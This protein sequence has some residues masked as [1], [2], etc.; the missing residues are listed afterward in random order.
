[1]N[2]IDVRLLRRRREEGERR[3]RDGT[4]ERNDQ[5]GPDHDVADPTPRLFARHPERLRIGAHANPEAVEIL[6][7]GHGAVAPACSR[8][9]RFAA[10][11][12]RMRSSIVSGTIDGSAFATFS[13]Y[14]TMRCMFL[15]ER[16]D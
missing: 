7:L 16:D 8:R 9:R 13:V 14:R 10:S 4:R 15:A 1:M 5:E 11:L 2:G 12:S 6:P 3:G